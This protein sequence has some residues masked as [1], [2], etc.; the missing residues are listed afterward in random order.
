M[1]K[2]TFLV[3]IIFFFSA[4]S[5]NAQS[6]IC[7]NNFNFNNP[8]I[9][10]NRVCPLGYV[11]VGEVGNGSTSGGSSPLQPI[12][13][14]LN[15]NAAERRERLAREAAAAEAQRQREHEERM[16]R[17]QNPQSNIRTSSIPENARCLQGLW[18]VTRTDSKDNPGGSLRITAEGL[19]YVGKNLVSNDSSITSSLGNNRIMIRQGVMGSKGW[20]QNLQLV[21]D[22]LEGRISVR[23]GAKG[24]ETYDLRGERASNTPS[25]CAAGPSN[26]SVENQRGTTITDGLKDLSQLYENGLLTDEEFTAAKK[27][28]L[29]L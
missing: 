3:P 6:V 9:I 27:R 16:L 19:I 8:R 1:K 26:T 7:E 12:Y 24:V 20:T 2:L 25:G 28:L 14:Q 23:D 22:H 18:T 4:P 10:A 15:N 13:D 17:L 5:V 29:G 21:N 11:K